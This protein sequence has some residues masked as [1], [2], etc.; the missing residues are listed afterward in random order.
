MATL[1]YTEKYQAIQICNLLTLITS[2]VLKQSTWNQVQEQL[3]EL[4]F[5]QWYYTVVSYQNESFPSKWELPCL[6][7][8]SLELW[9][10]E[11]ASRQLSFLWKTIILIG[12]YGT[13]L[14]AL[15]LLLYK[16]G[17]QRLSYKLV[18]RYCCWSLVKARHESFYSC[19]CKINWYVN[20]WELH[21]CIGDTDA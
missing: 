7:P 13:F 15:S 18:D 3:Q 14:S 1:S 20:S 21:R 11:R 19:I 10:R 16:L 8:S 2:K 5:Q 6:P 4:R 12:P 17:D 9:K